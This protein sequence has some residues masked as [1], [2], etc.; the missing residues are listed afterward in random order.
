MKRVIASIATASVLSGCA[1]QPRG[2]SYVPLVDMQGKD[3]A[4]F[5]RDVKDCQAYAQQRMSA[6]EGAA[7]GAS[8]TP[9]PGSVTGIAREPFLFK[10]KQLKP[11]E[12]FD[13]LTYVPQV[14]RVVKV[15]VTLEAEESKVLW[16]DTPARK[17][18]R[19]QSKMEPV[20]NFKLP[21]ATTWIDAE[22]FEPLM[23]EFD[24]P[25]L[26]GRVTFLRA[27][28]GYSNRTPRGGLRRRRGA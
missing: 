17:L 8:D 20:G 9:W 28:N 23:V 2:A 18:L 1:M 21:P 3:Q 16:P 5:T 4:T 22:N 7:A 26:G 13:Y 25:A 19:Y 6:G 10:E 24:F 12:S 11:G 15:T 14:N 27:L